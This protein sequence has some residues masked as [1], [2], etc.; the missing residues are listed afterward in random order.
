MNY[1]D[2]R[3]WDLTIGRLNISRW[4]TLPSRPEHPVRHPIRVALWNR[5][6]S[7]STR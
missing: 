3:H 1:G 4:C 7:A 5:A 6:G 2:R